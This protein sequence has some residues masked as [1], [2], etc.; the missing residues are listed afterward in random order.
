MHT[1]TKPA[2]EL[3]LRDASPDQ[4]GVMT[5]LA[6]GATY[7]SATWIVSMLGLLGELTGGSAGL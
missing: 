3:R 1:K 7:R 4:R 6:L 5:A 2:A